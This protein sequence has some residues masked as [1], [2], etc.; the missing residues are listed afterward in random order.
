MSAQYGHICDIVC[1]SALDKERSHA[2]LMPYLADK[3]TLLTGQS[4]VGKTS[5]LN[6]LV[7]GCAR[8]VG[9]LSAK[10]ERGKNTTRHSE[11]FMLDNGG[12]LADSPGFNAYELDNFTPEDILDYT[13]ELRAVANDCKFNNCSHIGEDASICAVKRAVAAGEINIDRYTR[14]CE[15]YRIA[16]EKEDK[17][18]E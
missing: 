8:D 7:E 3:F 13:L 6:I 16:K 1:V 4:A 12:L 15:L 11:I 17:K 5:L 14:F 9:D 10:T 2:A 18:Y